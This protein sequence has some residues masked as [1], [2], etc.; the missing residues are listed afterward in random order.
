MCQ[1]SVAGWEKCLDSVF[2]SYPWAAGK[3]T[4][5]EGGIRV[6][7]ILRWLGS[8]PG[9]RQVDEP[10]SNMDLF[11]TVVHL[12]GASVPE[13]RWGCTAVTQ[14]FYHMSVKTSR[15]WNLGHIL[16]REREAGGAWVFI[17]AHSEQDPGSDQRTHANEEGG[18]K[19][20]KRI[21]S[22]TVMSSCVCQRGDWLLIPALLSEG[23]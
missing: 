7:G 12:S 21:S 17:R 16:K 6:P 9:G 23:K 4:N 18:I 15:A 3:S 2:L 14:H 8:I 19:V 20:N 22:V 13:D 1:D 5:W 10:T 11:P